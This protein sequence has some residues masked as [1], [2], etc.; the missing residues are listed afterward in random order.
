MLLSTGLEPNLYVIKIMFKG[1]L[2]F[3]KTK[4]NNNSLNKMSCLISY[5]NSPDFKKKRELLDK[6]GKSC[7]YRKQC[8]WFFFYLQNI[9][10]FSLNIKLSDSPS[11]FLS[12]TFLFRRIYVA[13]KKKC[14]YYSG[15]G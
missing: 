1:K 14:W 11:T 9:N 10:K 12:V 8:H 7:I 6:K 4:D 13:K 2:T 5:R 15:M 3:M